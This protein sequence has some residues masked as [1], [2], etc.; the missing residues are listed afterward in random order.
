MHIV[1]ICV[2]SVNGRDLLIVDPRDRVAPVTG[3]GRGIGAAP[4][5]MLARCGAVVDVNYLANRDR[6]V[7]V[8]EEIADAGGKAVVVGAE[9]ADPGQV[10]A[11]VDDVL[12]AFGGLHVLVNNAGI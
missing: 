6:A 12:A 8:A 5:R 7:R 11:V 9:V 4:S 10:A 2:R 3:G 1:H